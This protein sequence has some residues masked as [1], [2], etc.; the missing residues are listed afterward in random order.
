MKITKK[1]ITE[2][3]R[4]QLGSNP[5]W[6]VKAMVRIYDENQNESEK[7][8]G[9]TIDDNGIGFNGVDAEL[10]SSFSRQV[11]TR[12]SLSNKQLGIVFKKMPKYHSQVIEMSDMT[13]LEPM[14]KKHF[15]KNQTE[16]NLK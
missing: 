10:L 13:K 15:T 16:L 14:V 1:K 12:G 4:G 8:S 5:A 6:A 9:A 11:K 2:F 3:V 7:L